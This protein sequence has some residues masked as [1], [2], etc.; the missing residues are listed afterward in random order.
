M[1]DDH[2]TRKKPA[3]ASGESVRR[4]AASAMESL[5]RKEE[6]FRAVAD[7]SSDAIITVDARGRIVFWNKRAQSIFGYGAEE[8]LGKSAA[9]LVP[10]LSWNPP[11]SGPELLRLAG[12]PRIL[13]NRAELSGR[14][15]DGSRFPLEVSQ[16][17]WAAAKEKYCTAL[18]RDLTEPKRMEA[19][20][21]QKFSELERTLNE[22]VNALALTVEKRD[23]YTAGHQRRVA[24]LACALMQEM[25][26]PEEEIKGMR[27]T[28]LLHD[29]G[30]ISVPAEILTKPDP[31]N[32]IE[33]LLVQMHPKA[34]YEIL[35]NIPFPRPVAQSILQHHERMDG[36]GYPQGL[37]G[38]NIILEARVLAVADVVEAI[39]SPRP[40]RPV[41][42]VERALEEISRNRG[43]LYDPE[44]VDSCLKLFSARGFKFE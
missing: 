28:G 9:G 35:V 42:G 25:G 12:E 43:K 38:G 24:Q 18:V 14:K 17:A 30:K 39:T 2:P 41:Y 40:Y 5:R 23:P 44:I 37:S 29:I 1:A 27:V 7:S 4:T 10:E 21:A 16:A 31:L 6:H 13:Q 11:L 19:T 36:S 15:K 34:G 20:L 3:G 26:L 8:I 33:V 22:T 32:S